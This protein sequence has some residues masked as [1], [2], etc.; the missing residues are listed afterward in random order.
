[1]CMDLCL[2]VASTYI[3]IIELHKKSGNAAV[4]T[5]EEVDAGQHHVCC[6]GNTE[7][8]GGGVHH[9]GD[10][11][12]K[13]NNS[14]SLRQ[15]ERTDRNPSDLIYTIDKVNTAKLISNVAHTH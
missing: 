8:E 13:E 5:D 11:P 9:G 7:D 14:L 4:D 6:A 10:G 15:I 2:F 1:M 12:P 3:I